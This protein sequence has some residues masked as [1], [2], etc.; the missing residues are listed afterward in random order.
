MMTMTTLIQ[1]CWV[2]AFR[3]LAVYIRRSKHPRHGAGDDNFL[4]SPAT[5]QERND[6]FDG[7][8]SLA[9]HMLFSLF[10]GGPK[11]ASK[12]NPQSPNKKNNQTDPRRL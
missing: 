4:I 3:L 5:T 12:Q 9:R 6:R 8:D 2:L 1:R 7:G 11:G 10:D